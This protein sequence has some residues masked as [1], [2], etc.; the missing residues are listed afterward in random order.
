MLPDLNISPVPDW[1]KERLARWLCEWRAERILVRED[2]EPAVRC[3]RDDAARSSE[4]TL[5]APT[6]NEPDPAGGQIRLLAPCSA[7]HARVP[8]YVAVLAVLRDGVLLAA[9]YSGFAE[10]A[11]EGELLTGREAPP[12]RVLAV[13][14][15]REVPASTLR[16]SWLVDE[17]T[18]E[19]TEDALAL[20]RCVSA[21]RKL[22]LRL[23]RR[24]GP[25]VCHP[26]DPRRAYR[27]WAVASLSAVLEALG[28][29][30]DRNAYP[31]SDSTGL[32]RAAEP[33][34]PYRTQ[35]GGNPAPG[36]DAVSSSDDGCPQA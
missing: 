6:S 36:Q 18:S 35:P 12:L 34:A 13:W 21:Q 22:P 32:L 3:V 24:V 33:P 19:E 10:P 20:W 8:L 15:A 7:G 11:T 31:E 25:P 9:P 30:G 29:R 27:N 17:L 5:A 4:G 16:D 28:S 14:N 26:E 23:R 2:V 1:Q